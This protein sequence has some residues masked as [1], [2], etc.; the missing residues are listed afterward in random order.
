MDRRASGA[1]ALVVR[2]YPAHM[3]VHPTAVKRPSISGYFV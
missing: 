3:R 1:H 2:F